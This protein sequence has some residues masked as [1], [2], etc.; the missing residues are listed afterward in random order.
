MYV[1]RNV[2]H[3]RARN[4]QSTQAQFRRNAAIKDI[5]GNCEVCVVEKHWLKRHDAERLNGNVSWWRVTRG[6]DLTTK[7]TYQRVI[8]RVVYWFELRK[9]ELMCSL[10]GFRLDLTL[11][12]VLKNG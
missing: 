1:K 8:R 5:G 12:R 2:L 6:G 10:R 3:F 11:P 4:G 7:P 9:R